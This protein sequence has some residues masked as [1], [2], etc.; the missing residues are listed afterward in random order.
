MNSNSTTYMYIRY[1]SHLIRNT[2]HI[3]YN[4][5]IGTLNIYIYITT[6]CVALLAKPSDTQ[7][8]GRGLKTRPSGV[9]RAIKISLKIIFR[10][11]LIY[12]CV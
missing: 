4:V 12:N 7:A 8:V 10:S 6:A 9:G 3:Y 1:I 5:P 2:T 11:Y